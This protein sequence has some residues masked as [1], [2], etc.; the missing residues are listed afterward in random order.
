MVTELNENN[1]N[2]T[3][4]KTVGENKVQAVFVSTSNQ[5]SLRYQMPCFQMN[6]LIKCTAIKK[7][8]LDS[9]FRA[10]LQKNHK[11]N[12][13]SIG[14]EQEML[15]IFK[16]NLMLTGRQVDFLYEPVVLHK[17]DEISYATI[18][19][20]FDL[21]KSLYLPRLSSN[22]HFEEVCKGSQ[23]DSNNEQLC[24]II[25]SNSQ[26]R[27]P[28]IVFDNDLKTKLIQNAENDE[29]FK[30]YARF[31]YIYTD[32]QAEF[33]EKLMKNSKLKSIETDKVIFELTF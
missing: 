31:C 7:D 21:N 3:L 28:Q 2:E 6:A 23:Y 5:I 32:I 10:Y 22:D 13:K 9:N 25:L 12:V 30:Q 14:K 18:Q 29:F 15:L 17:T 8:S 24:V 19:Q 4:Q 20:T 33:I 11:V 26:N 27:M 16:E 1:F